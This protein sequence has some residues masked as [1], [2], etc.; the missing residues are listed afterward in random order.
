M[1]VVDK[2]KVLTPRV[3]QSGVNIPAEAGTLGEGV[4]AE[5]VTA[6]RGARKAQ[7]STAG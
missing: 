1:C 7:G 5:L 2:I 6:S 4:A 3:N